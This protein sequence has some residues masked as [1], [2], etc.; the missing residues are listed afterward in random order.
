MII[1]LGSATGII[2]LPPYK[3]V[4]ELGNPLPIVMTDYVF[5]GYLV[6]QDGKYLTD[7]SGNKL[8]ANVRTS[9]GSTLIELE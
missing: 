6:N 3:N 8:V 1:E 4:I 2:D 9:V 5:A 7:Q